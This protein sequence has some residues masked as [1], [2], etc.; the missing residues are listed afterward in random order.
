MHY[1][2]LIKAQKKEEGCYTE[3]VMGINIS[4]YIF[5]FVVKHVYDIVV[6]YLWY[7]SDICVMLWHLCCNICVISMW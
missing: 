1:Q 4:I 5:D 3:R 7:Q 6:I 2:N